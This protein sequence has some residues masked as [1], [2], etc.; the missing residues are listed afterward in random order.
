MCGSKFPQGVLMADDQS[1]TSRCRSAL[2]IDE[3]GARTWDGCFVD[4]GWLISEDAPNIEWK[5]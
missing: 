2:L 1:L 4:L 5:G 3:Q